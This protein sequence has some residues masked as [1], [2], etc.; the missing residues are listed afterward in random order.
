MAR[1]VALRFA[2]PGVR[3]ARSSESLGPGTI[4]LER[5]GPADGFA[6]PGARPVLPALAASRRSRRRCAADWR[7]RTARR[8]LTLAKA[9]SNASAF[10]AARL[11]SGLALP[12]PPRASTFELAPRRY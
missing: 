10:M 3:A 1:L 12:R 11:F 8:R 6:L 9:S 2:R 7:A 4:P 5:E